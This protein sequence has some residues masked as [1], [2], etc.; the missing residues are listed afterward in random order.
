MPDIGIQVRTFN[1]SLSQAMLKA[2]AKAGLTRQEMCEKVLGIAYGTMATYLAFKSYPSEERLLAIAIALEAQPDEIF[3]PELAHV[4]LT[5]QPD[6]VVVSLDEAI[7][8]GFG[9]EDP[10]PL[11]DHILTGVTVEKVLATI[12][13]REAVVLRKRYG[14]DG[15]EPMTYDEIGREQGVTRERIRQIEAKSLR[16][17][18]HF[19]RTRMLET[20]DEKDVECNLDRTQ[21]HVRER[22]GYDKNRQVI[23]GRYC[24]SCGFDMNAKQMIEEAPMTLKQRR[25]AGTRLEEI[26][27]EL[28]KK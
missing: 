22:G 25:Q 16:K 19:S 13:D 20:I 17:L 6:P 14:L 11:I 7:A 10:T 8:L 2:Q 12:S 27:D 23:H 1:Y 28:P 5:K 21:H 9:G 26:R 24:R 15:E 18:R 4:R 3:P